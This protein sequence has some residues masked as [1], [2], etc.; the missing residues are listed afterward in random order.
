M[1]KILLNISLTINLLILSLFE[2]ASNITIPLYTINFY[3]YQSM[4]FGYLIWSVYLLGLAILPCADDMKVHNS[5]NE[6]LTEH[7]LYKRTSTSHDHHT[8]VDTCSPLCACHCCHVH[9]Y[10]P[11][12][13]TLSLRGFTCLFYNLYPENSE[14]ISIFDFLKPPRRFLSFSA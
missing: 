7:V 5:A 10:I 1:A 8:S 4:K 2:K 6:I 11:D 13:I 14:G 12:S 3:L 9:V